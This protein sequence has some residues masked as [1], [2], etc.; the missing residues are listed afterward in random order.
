MAP[1]SKELAGII[2]PHDSFG[3]YLDGN[4]NTTDPEK[5]LQNF[6]KAGNL[7][8][9]VWSKTTIDGYPVTAS[10]VDPSENDGNFKHFSDNKLKT[11]L[12]A[13]VRISKYCL[14]IA[15]C[16]NDDCCKPLRTNVQDVLRS[17]F[18][19]TPIV[20][21]SEPSLLDPGE[22]G[23]KCKIADFYKSLALR[24]LRPKGYKQCDVVP[25][26]L[27]CPSVAISNPDYVCPYVRCQ[28]I[29]TTKELQKLHLKATQHHSFHNEISDIAANDDG[30]DTDGDDEKQAVHIDDGPCTIPDLNMF[31]ENTWEITYE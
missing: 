14:Q 25:Y 28:R 27:Y 13:H 16:T 15:K 4:G 2:L 3:S 31:M 8:S 19:P 26:D 24:H 17:K 20:L 11:W 22:K 9:D 7:L 5:E 21:N 6:R 10:W 12:E 1:L 23:E 29:F 30:D 18:L